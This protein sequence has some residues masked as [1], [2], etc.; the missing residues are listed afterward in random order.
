M[1]ILVVEEGAG[2]N[3]TLVSALRSDGHIVSSA[4]TVDET[5]HLVAGQL[6]DVLV[7]DLNLPDGRATDILARWKYRNSLIAIVLRDRGFPAEIEAYAEAGF[8][9]HMVKPIDVACLKALLPRRI[10]PSLKEQMVIH[11]MKR[12]AAAAPEER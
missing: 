11:R 7:T 5:L 2:S 3:S 8:Q 6:Y 12:F 9:Y 1:R 4:S 10:W